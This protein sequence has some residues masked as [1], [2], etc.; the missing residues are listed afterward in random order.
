MHMPIPIGISEVRE[1]INL[2]SKPWHAFQG[3]RLLVFGSK[4]VGKT[5]LWRHLQDGD[6][7]NASISTTLAPEEIGRFKLRDIKVAG[8]LRVRILGVDVPGD[9]SLRATWED[10]LCKMGP[11]PHG[12]I[13]MLDNV[14]DAEQGLPKTGYDPK[15]LEEHHEAF[16]HLSNLVLSNSNVMDTLQAMLI[17]VNK[18]D[19]WGSGSLQYGDIIDAAGLDPFVTRFDK[20][21]DARFRRRIQPCSALYGSNVQASVAWMAKNFQ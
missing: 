19:S 14:E 11:P 16:K 4:G 8:L 6:S 12:I 17:L 7:V 5:T 1:I 3:Y 2:L 20:E 9:L 10:A 21:L 13:F 15:R 18:S